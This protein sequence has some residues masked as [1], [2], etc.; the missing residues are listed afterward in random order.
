MSSG[1]GEIQVMR[2]IQF[3][4][5]TFKGAAGHLKSWKHH[6][7]QFFSSHERSLGPLFRITV[8]ISC[9]LI[10]YR[11]FNFTE[12]LRHANGGNAVVNKDTTERSYEGID[13]PCCNTDT[14]GTD[15]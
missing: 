9:C 3:A 8:R 14:D 7:H 12:L 5:G 2:F 6:Y 11:L 13:F 1:K 10:S 15:K 4:S